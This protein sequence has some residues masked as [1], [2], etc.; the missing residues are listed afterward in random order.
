[1]WWLS[2]TAFQSLLLPYVLLGMELKASGKVLTDSVVAML[3]VFLYP[4]LRPAKDYTVGKNHPDLVDVIF[5]PYIVEP[6][7]RSGMR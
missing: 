3:R 7:R 4:H 6:F 1:M 5:G 2:C